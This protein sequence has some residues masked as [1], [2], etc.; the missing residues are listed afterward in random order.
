MVVP[1]L[2]LHLKHCVGAR[3]GI[4]GSG[5]AAGALLEA[6]LDELH[7]VLDALHGDFG[8]AADVDFLFV[9]F[10]TFDL[11]L[12]IEQVQQFDAI[13]FVERDC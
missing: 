5:G 4:V 13:N 10:K 7:D 12:L 2:E 9:V 11:L 3:T 6:V 8:E 1:S